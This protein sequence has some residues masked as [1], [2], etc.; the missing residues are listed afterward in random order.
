MNKPISPLKILKKNLKPA[1][2]RFEPIAYEPTDLAS[3]PRPLGIAGKKLKILFICFEIQ[4]TVV[5][6]IRKRVVLNGKTVDIE[7]KYER[8]N[9]DPE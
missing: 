7:M 9:C 8:K 2:V 3:T 1:E 6:E 5:I 4:K